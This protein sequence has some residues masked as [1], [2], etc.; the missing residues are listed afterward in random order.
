MHWTSV[1]VFNGE[2]VLVWCHVV[3]IVDD[4]LKQLAHACQAF[5]CLVAFYAGQGV[6]IGEA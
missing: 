4:K 2:G 6:K 1:Y 3:E 5:P